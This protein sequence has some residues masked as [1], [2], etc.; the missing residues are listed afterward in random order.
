[1]LKNL[2]D[3]IA[4]A[5]IKAGK[6]RLSCPRCQSEGQLTGQTYTCSTCGFIGAPLEWFPSASGAPLGSPGAP[7]PASNIKKLSPSPSSTA[8]EI[9]ASG[10]SGGLF[11]FAI[12]WLL[13]TGLI[14]A[15]FVYSITTKGWDSIESD[16]PRE[17]LP[18]ILPLFFGIFWAIGLGVLYFALKTKL[19]KHLLLLKD[20]TL[21]HVRE[22]IG[23]KKT[24]S[25]PFSQITSIA[26]VEFYSK[27]YVPVYGIEIRSSSKKSR[28]G[29]SLDDLE[30][31]WLVAELNHLVFPPKENPTPTTGLILEMPNPKSRFELPVPPTV[32]KAADYF[33]SALGLTIV[34]VFIALGLSP[35]MNDAGFFRFLWLGFSSLFL[36]A[37]LGGIIKHVSQRNISESILF[38]GEKLTLRKSRNNR[39]LSEKSL[40]LADLRRVALYPSS[41]SNSQGRFAAS[42]ITPDQVI[43]IFRWKPQDLARPFVT[44]LRAKLNLPE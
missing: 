7:P 8:F 22:F 13:I 40:P 32:M 30:K 1:M 28:F 31:G 10:K 12:F 34:S 2:P 44:E 20:H 43:P 38:D 6:G 9:P 18:I 23:R 5:A 16:F 35:L 26:A 21:V 25:F 27:N 14:T 42:L 41:S 33:G 17:W 39:T 29:A 36:L 15:G 37:I 24:I 3:K 4:R 19:S 11:F